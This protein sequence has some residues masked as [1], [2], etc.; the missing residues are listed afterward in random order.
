MNL[1]DMKKRLKLTIKLSK[2]ILNIKMF[3]FKKEMRYM[4]LIDMKKRSKLTIKLLILI[5]NLKMLFM[6]KESRFMDLIDMKKHSIY[7]TKLLN[8]NLIMHYIIALEVRI[9]WL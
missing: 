8:Y 9:L 5:L 3:L 2:L 6:A 7:L 4:N 1:I